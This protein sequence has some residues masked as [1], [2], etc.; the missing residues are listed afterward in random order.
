M[1]FLTSSTQLSS[2]RSSLLAWYRKQKRDLP[3]RHSR[4]PYAIWVSEIMLQQTTVKTVIPYYERFLKKFPTPQSVA[5]A[6]ESDLLQV[7]QGL[8]YYS[9]IRNFQRAIRVVMDEFNGKIPS[10]K[11]DLLKLSGLGDYTASAIAS[12]AFNEPV[13]VVDGNVMRV[14][15]RLFTYADDITKSESKKF[16][17]QTAKT[18]IDKKHP[19]DFNQAMMELG[20]TVCTP[21]KPTCLFCPVEKFCT[22]LTKGSV[23]K[24]PVKLKKIKYVD[25]SWI[26]QILVQSKTNKVWLRQRNSD[27]LL[28]GLWEFPLEK[29]T[30]PPQAIKNKIRHSIMNKRMTIFTNKTIVD[31]KTKTPS[32]VL[33]SKNNKQEKGRWILWSELANLPLTTITRKIVDTLPINA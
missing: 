15:A 24:F 28:S 18:L 30:L 31:Q 6:D 33:N 9:R 2:F 12:I 32:L 20:A 19:G 16:F 11:L 14:L 8:G 23:E 10:K 1:S 21:Q 3:W 22:A 13:A 17:S 29:T 27:E 5:Q 25:E 26:A 4:D 7:W